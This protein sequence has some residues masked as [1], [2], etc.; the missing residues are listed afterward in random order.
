MSPRFSSVTSASSLVYGTLD[1]WRRQMVE[2]EYDLLDAALHRAEHIRSAV[3]DLPG[4]RPM[5]R[6]VVHAE[7]AAPCARS[8]SASGRATR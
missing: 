4:L 2:Q 7:R 6:E 8:A 3:G 1:G 5:G